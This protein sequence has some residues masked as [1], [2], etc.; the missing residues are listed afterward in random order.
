MCDET[1]KMNGLIMY[2]KDMIH[3]KEKYSHLKIDRT[4]LKSR[5]WVITRKH[6]KTSV[7]I[8]D[9]GDLQ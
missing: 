6:L 2:I 7:G 5:K 4:S 8:P 3:L 1:Q 9:R